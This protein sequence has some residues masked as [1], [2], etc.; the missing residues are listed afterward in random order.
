MENRTAE[1][2]ALADSCSSCGPWRIDDDGRFRIVLSVQADIPIVS[3]P[4][5]CT[6]H[7]ETR[8]VAAHRL[9]DGSQQRRE[10][11]AVSVENHVAVPHTGAVHPST[12]RDG[13]HAPPAIARPVQ[14]RAWYQAQYEAELALVVL[15]F[16]TSEGF[17]DVP[18]HDDRQD[19]MD[20]ERGASVGWE[21]CLNFW[22]MGI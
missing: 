19:R 16:G 20:G 15:Q 2:P 9:L 11:V 18:H 3:T 7:H 21:A 17:A 12:G 10:A 14:R 1:A 22:L 5:F 8:C 13:R 4:V 6:D